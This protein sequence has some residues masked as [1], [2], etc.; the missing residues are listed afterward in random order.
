MA[1]FSL[2]AIV[3]MPLA[4]EILERIS[5][6]PLSMTPVAVARIVL[7]SLIPL[8][9]DARARDTAATRA[10][11]RKVATVVARVLFPVAL[12]NR[13]PGSGNVGSDR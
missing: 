13:G 8:A 12:A 1:I 7:I 11:D 5:A 4:L 9:G 10:S 6:R 2:S 3:I